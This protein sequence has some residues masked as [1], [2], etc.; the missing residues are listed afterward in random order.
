[1]ARGGS[2]VAAL[3]LALGGAVQPARAGEADVVAAKVACEAR[4]CSFAVTLKHADEGWQHYADR[5]EVLAG[6]GSVLGTRVLQH[7]HVAEQ[8]V[9]REL[10]GV[11]IPT[12]LETV[13]VRARDSVHGYGGAELTVE[14]PE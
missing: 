8:P 3:A 11:R 6:D 12:G 1:V 2:G 14:I 10:A 4:V 5:F 13:R 7:P 9:T